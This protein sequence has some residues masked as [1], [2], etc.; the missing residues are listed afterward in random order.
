MFSVSAEFVRADRRAAVLVVSVRGEVDRLTVPRLVEELAAAWQ[1][2]PAA[3]VLDLSGV[4]F[5][6]AAGL[7]V[8]AAAAREDPDLHVVATTRAVRRPVEVTGMTDLLSMHPDRERALAAAAGSA[9]VPASVVGAAV[10]VQRRSQS[11]DHDVCR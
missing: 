4:S 10:P 8:L 1:A 3:L 9:P 5:L 2:R 11:L 6:G 7:R